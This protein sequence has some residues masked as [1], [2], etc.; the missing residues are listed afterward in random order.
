M[1]PNIKPEELNNTFFTII[2]VNNSII[3]VSYMDYRI[4]NP[5]AQTSSLST[6]VGLQVYTKTFKTDIR[7]GF[8]SQDHLDDNHSNYIKFINSGIQKNFIEEI[9][10]LGEQNRNENLDNNRLDINIKYFKTDDSVLT[11]RKLLSKFISAGSFIAVNGRIGPANFM[12][13]N[14]KTYKYILNYLIGIQHVYDGN[15]I[16]QLGTIAYNIN[17]SI[18]DGLILMGR[19]NNM[20]NIGTHC[21]ILTD[22]DGFIKFDEIKTPQGNH[23]IMYYCIASVGSAYSQY[24][25]LNSRS[26]SYYRKEKLKKLNSI[27]NE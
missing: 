14:S 4:N 9:S 17:N 18:D 11:S 3:D 13:S 25:T 22:T 7:L 6:T 20:E 8:K 10:K 19:K 26:I 15:G 24:L 2:P 27:R 12:I 21:L 16:L 5:S 1:I 23:I